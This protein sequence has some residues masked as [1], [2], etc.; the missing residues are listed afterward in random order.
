[1]CEELYEYDSREHARTVLVKSKTNRNMWGG[2]TYVGTTEKRNEDII[3]KTSVYRQKILTSTSSSVSTPSSFLSLE[4]CDNNTKDQ[5]NVTNEVKYLESCERLNVPVVATVLRNLSSHCLN[6][7]HRGIDEKAFRAITVSLKNNLSVANINLTDNNLG[8]K[9]AK[10]ICYIFRYNSCITRLNLSCNQLGDEGLCVLLYSLENTK[11]LNHLNLSKNRITDK[12]G[13]AI[14]DFLVINKSVKHLD[15]SENKLSDLSSELI[16]E[17]IE[18]NDT[19]K[20]LDLSWNHL[21]VKASIELAKSLRKGQE[22]TTI[23]L[24]WNGINDTGGI[25]LGKSLSTNDVLLELD[26]SH[27]RISAKGAKGLAVGLITN[28]TLEILRLRGNAILNDGF[29]AI[30]DACVK[31]KNSSLL[32]IDVSDISAGTQNKETIDFLS[33]TNPWLQVHV[34]GFSSVSDYVT[35]YKIFNELISILREYAVKGNLRAV[36][37]LHKWN[38]ESDYVVTKDEF[39]KSI[40]SRMPALTTSQ[41]YILMSWLHTDKSNSIDYKVEKCE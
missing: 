3:R 1:M 34:R 12:S 7:A 28:E 27:N 39:R 17:G 10:E 9:G 33:S 21:R 11:Q 20:V 37:L 2:F 36:D 18:V 6:L 29:Q 30:L 8:I 19:L 38:K 24:S 5:E 41:I 13:R 32:T 40:K 26:I 14:E 22:L 16:G 31:N 25:L 35:N 15:L 23:H 4:E